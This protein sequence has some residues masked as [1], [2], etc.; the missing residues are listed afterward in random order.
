[1]EAMAEK[2]AENA[3]NAGPVV[4]R[5]ESVG[6]AGRKDGYAGRSSDEGCLKFG[7]RTRCL[8][9]VEDHL[10]RRGFEILER[11]WSCKAGTV[12]FIVD[13]GG[14]IA[15]ITMRVRERGALNALLEGEDRITLER[16]AAAYLADYEGGCARVRFDMVSIS[17][18]GADLAFI[19]YISDAFEA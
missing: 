6:S 12:D 5:A 1:M 18:I 10:E 19:M 16:I 17:L 14:E 2:D 3:A 15:F 13:D 8:N 11:Y 9:L 4:R 7:F